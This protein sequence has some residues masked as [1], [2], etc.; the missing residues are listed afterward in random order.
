MISFL[1]RQPISMNKIACKTALVGYILLHHPLSASTHDLGSELCWRS[2]GRVFCLATVGVDTV[3]KQKLG[4]YIYTNGPGPQ[5]IYFKWDGKSFDENMNPKPSAW[6]IPHK[7]EN[8]RY[9]GMEIRI[10]YISSNSELVDRI[11]VKVVDC[12]E[13]TNALYKAPR[14]QLVPG[15]W[16]NNVNGDWHSSYCS[17]I[18]KLPVSRYEL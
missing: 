8:S 13:G 6:K 12:H 7:G 4:G 16:K 14:T 18:G 17:T 2:R 9:L 5:V 11:L 15:K 1:N 3:G 10:R